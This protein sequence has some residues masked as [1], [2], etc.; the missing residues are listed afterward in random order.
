METQHAYEIIGLIG[1]VLYMVSYWLLQLGRLNGNGYCYATLNIA[2]ALFVLVSLR[3]DFNLAS[4]LIQLA[5]ISISIFGIVR[6]WNIR[7]MSY[8]GS[9]LEPQ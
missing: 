1:F 3:L 6:T 2:A 5:W 9:D 7:R 8:R 4:M